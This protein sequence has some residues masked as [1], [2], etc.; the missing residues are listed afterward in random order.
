MDRKLRE[1]LGVYMFATAQQQKASCVWGLGLSS[2]AYEHF[3]ENNALLEPPW[4]FAQQYWNPLE[5]LMVQ[6]W[7]FAKFPAQ[8][9]RLVR[10]IHPV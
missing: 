7:K 3:S 5:M 8:I 4:K 1:I 10:E 2:R 6:S 9:F